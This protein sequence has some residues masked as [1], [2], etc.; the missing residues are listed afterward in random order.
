M[1]FKPLRGDETK[2]ST[3]WLEGSVA[4]RYDSHAL[5]TPVLGKSI[6]FKV[7]AMRFHHLLIALALAFC[8]T[9][10]I[11]CVSNPTPHPGTSDPTN[12]SLN[13]A[14]GQDTGTDDGDRA[15]VEA[16]ST[17]PT[18]PLLCENVEEILAEDQSCSVDADC[19]LLID[20]NDCAC[21]RAFAV[22]TAHDDLSA[23][24]LM[25]ALAC[26]LTEEDL[27]GPCI[28]DLAATGNSVICAEGLCEAVIPTE[29]CDACSGD[30]PAC[31]FCDSDVV[32]DAICVSGAWTCNEG[33]IAPECDDP[34]CG[35]FAGELCCQADGTSSDALCPTPSQAYCPDG[36]PPV[37]ACGECGDG[38]CDLSE[39][40]DTCPEECD[41]EDE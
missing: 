27:A 19:V 13:E 30:A 2:R 29:G 10:T 11:G 24:L 37:L 8:A 12:V 21:T 40:A 1:P 38:I 36:S 34:S 31:V 35:L 6:Y 20:V 28:T 25:D 17:L 39:D 14:G 9:W 23:D 18:E 5:T 22:S 7:L 4:A 15:D 32:L 41:A 33:E 16:G 3:D 26:N